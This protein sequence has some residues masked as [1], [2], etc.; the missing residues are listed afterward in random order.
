MG[1]KYWTTVGIQYGQKILDNSG[2]TVWAE[3]TGQ[4][5]VIGKSWILTLYNNIYTT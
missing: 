1:R 5:I 3:N 2:Y 4:Q